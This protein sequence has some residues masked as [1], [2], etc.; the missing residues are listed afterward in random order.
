MWLLKESLLSV[1]IT[2]S[3]SP[4]VISKKTLVRNPPAQDSLGLEA[5]HPDSRPLKSSACSWTSFPKNMGMVVGPGVK[6]L[7]YP[8]GLPISADEAPFELGGSTL[9]ISQKE[10]PILLP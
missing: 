2:F 4:T 6:A 1:P 9:F 8:E 5:F 10:A 7:A 3:Q